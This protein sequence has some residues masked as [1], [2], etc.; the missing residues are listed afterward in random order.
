V[1]FILIG[2]A[3]ITIEKMTSQHLGE[4]IALRVGEEQQQFVGAI[5]DI[6]TIINAQIRP[7]VIIAG[8]QVVG[9][10]LIDT[11]YVQTNDVATLQ[12]LGLRKFFI[13]KQHQG[14]GYAKQTLQLLPDYLT[15]TYPN[16]TDVFLTVNCK[17]ETAKNLYLKSGFQDTSALYLGGPSGPQHVMKQVYNSL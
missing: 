9:F 17:N 2:G 14:K 12:S 11:I 16:Y 8:D 5:D 15:A 6:L 3:V 4:I 1:N 13:D 7:H 10:F